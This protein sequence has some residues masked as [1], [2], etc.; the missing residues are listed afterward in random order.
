MSVTDLLR[1]VAERGVEL[2]T[3]GSRLRFRAPQGALDA[4]LRDGLRADRAAVVAEL[5]AQAA[6]RVKVSLLSHNQ[7]AL[8]FIHQD[9]P[10]TA[11]YHVAVAARITSPV[12]ITAL[13]D[14]AQALTDRHPMLRGTYVLS[15][16]DQLTMRICDVI[17]VA[18]DR[19]DVTGTS[20][21]AL[22]DRVEAEHRRPFDLEHGPVFRCT[23][24]TTAPDD[25]VLLLNMHHI[26]GD[27]WS[28]LLAIEEF[29]VLYA[30]ASGLPTKPL[31]NPGKE[32]TAFVEWQTQF[33]ESVAGAA[34]G[35]AWQRTLAA[36]RGEVEIPL[37]RQRPPRKSYRG[38]AHR[39]A[40]PES[41]A[42]RL[43]VFAREQG[44]TLYTVLLASYAAVLYRLSGTTDV[45]IGTPTFGRS[46]NEF[47]RTIGHFVNPVPMRIAVEPT[48]SFRELLGRVSQTVRRALDGQDYPL[49]L[50]VQ[51][52]QVARDVSRSPLFEAFFGL[53][54]FE[55]LRDGVSDERQ[56][57][58][59]STT[60]DHAGLRIGPYAL[61]QRDTQFGLSLQ[62]SELD[63]GL[64]GSLTF[65]TDLYE[66]ETAARLCAHYITLLEGAILNVDQAVE[67]LP[68][69]AR[70][71][72]ADEA[73][74]APAAVSSAA[75]QLLDELAARDVRLQLD[76][77]KLKVNAPVGALTG[78]LKAR[79]SLLKAD[80]LA[81]LKAGS[82][83]HGGLRRVPRLAPLPISYAQQRLW[84]LDQMDPGNTHYNIALPIRVAGVLDVAAM[85]GALNAL[86]LRHEALRTRIRNVD[87]NP[88]AELMENV[89][90]VVRMADVSGLAPDARVR[91]AQRMAA[92]HGASSFDL[93]RGP[94]I[95][96]LLVRLADD[97]HVLALCMHHIASDGW[98]IAVASKEV[99]VLYDA[100]VAGLASPLPELTLQYID[101]AAWQREQMNSGLLAQ[102]LGFWQRELAGAPVLLELPTDRPRPMVL[103]YRGT[104]RRFR[105]EPE[106]LVSL[107]AF[108]RAN[109]V[110]LYMVLLAA[111]QVL[112]HRYSGQDDVVVGSPLANRDDPALEPVIGC[113]VNNIAMRG[114]LGGNPSFREFLAQTSTAVLAAFDN[115]EVPFDRVVEALRPERSTSHSPVFQAMF[116]LHSFPIDPAQPQGLQVELMPLPDDGSEASRFDLTMEID[117]HE[118]GLRTHFEYASDLFEEATVA[119][120]FGEYA[121]LL[122]SAVAEPELKLREIPMLTASDQRVLLDEVNATRF[123]HDRSVCIH[124]LVAAAAAAT[125]DAIAVQA[126]DATLT[127]GQLERRS[128]QM[129]QLLRER[130]VT[131]GSLVGV[132][133]DR[134][135]DLPVALL[136]VLKAGAAYVPVDPAHPAERL[137]YTLTDASVAC[138]ITE[139]KF[140]TLVESANAPLLLVDDDDG[141]ILAQSSHAPFSVVRPE[142]LAYVIYTSGSTGRP[143]GVEVEHRNV[144]NFLRSMAREPGF[145]RDDVLLA[146][147]TPSF[148]IAG[149]EVFLPL[150]CGARTVIASRADVLDGDQLI[151]LL[152]ETHATV[153]QATP[154]TW[155]LMLDT[156]WKGSSSLRVLCG[157]EAMPRDL[158]R[159]LLAKTG[160]IWNMYGPTETTIWSTTH[161]VTD[162]AQDI[163]IG[164]AIG[165]TTVYVLDESGRPA[166]IG[167]AGELCIG[168]EGVAR[169]YRRRP[170]LTQ[171]KFVTIALEGRAPERVYRTG[172]VARV[173]SDLT[174]EFVGRRDHQVKVR[175][176]RI[177]LGEIESVLVEH[178]SVR[179][180]VVLVREDTPGDQRLVAY[181]VP[182]DGEF[183]DAEALRSLLRARL[184]EYMVPSTI[185]PLLELP[186]TPNGKIDRKALPAPASLQ[187]APGAAVDIVMTD[188][189][190]RV[191]AIWR[192]V[193]RVEHLGV[194]DNFFDR[195]GHS[196]L[197]VKVHAALRREFQSELTLI[198][199]FQHTTIAAQAALL[200]TDAPDRDA[201][202]QRARARAARQVHA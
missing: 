95:S 171:E 70:R 29:F 168:G 8:W 36:P 103:T 180:A 112:L 149:L 64:D 45:I 4:A 159:E 5:R 154:A 91:E 65:C 20:E 121:E 170:E 80:L 16:D 137:V 58:Q 10:Q 32:Y 38:A 140:S 127:Y 34:L 15:D 114:R 172:D 174:L 181:V 23:L 113:F 67:T 2:W 93:A 89:G 173:R 96:C 187:P 55:Q 176:Y 71:L 177:E 84:F 51:H 200:S 130:G 134:I 86:P 185:V 202:M 124:E 33:I 62:F 106:Q 41:L 68:P 98:S 131:D 143:K 13:H 192:E 151:R 122:R 193:L 19:V 182:A 175:G 129:A 100:A 82:A 22:Q 6:K 90:N 99:C 44:T 72:G 52:A 169:G 135:A 59:L 74:T 167:V 101:F 150:I 119:R 136:A 197:V 46:Q 118:D 75:Q 66:Q 183:N 152:D 87:G 146:V 164:H 161:R 194:D 198:D 42:S 120:M 57:R 107:K 128:N 69:Q 53:M 79:M 49:L 85:V 92:A 157:G 54:A 30:E 116:T 178:A 142:D 21:A 199:L 17:D 179:R 162:A 141:A 24:F 144:V 9:V 191:A 48:L 1:Q 28:M 40:I 139:A 7:R 117:E 186:L 160:V 125:P 165:N 14:A 166:P 163:P 43:R 37:D 196:L 201:S 145:G 158:A 123:D 77:E 102:Q 189:Q 109:G 111:F 60:R 88:R 81:Q 47:N 132:C 115:R 3:E 35:D 50:M 184:P 76:G 126:S 188:P 25:H 12:N 63:G 97:D 195:G 78:E 11:A 105:I 153:M 56:T 61:R 31:P 190:R 108:A 110:T 148:D 73:A 39:F 155:R 147:T 26:A 18:F 104:R 83:P 156:G 94:L 133:L 27:A 138:V